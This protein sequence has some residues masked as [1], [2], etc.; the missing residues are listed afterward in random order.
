MA[1][2]TLVKRPSAFLGLTEP[3]RA[4]ADLASLLPGSLWL[5]S[6]PRGDGHRVV[7]L[8]GF[9][10]S[11]RSTVA[12]RAFLR[13]QGFDARGWELGTNLGGPEQR[14]DLDDLLRRLLAESEDP[15]SLV[16][17][18]LGGVLARNLARR[19]PQAIRSLITLGSPIGGSPTRT[20][21][22]R[23]YRQ[24]HR[25][26]NPELT[27]RFASGAR[28]EPPENVP[29]TAIWSRS[30]GIVPWRIACEQPGP[31]RE[32]LEVLSS[33]LGLAVNAA[34]LYAVADRLSQPREGWRPFEAPWWLRPVL[35]PA[36]V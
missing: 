6:A 18:S 34:V 8:P 4:A 20:R 33:H 32:N 11:D 10:G 19:Q 14:G 17:W 15:I 28:R 24:I 27:A 29:S 16:G 7:V 23:L 1:D 21:A 3:L 22:W 26:Q 9:T 35:R 12:L 2:E 31:G 36:K 30:D 5:S 25:G 13:R